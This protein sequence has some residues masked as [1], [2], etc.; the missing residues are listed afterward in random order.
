MTHESYKREIYYINGQMFTLYDFFTPEF[1]TR[2][3]WYRTQY[4]SATKDILGLLPKMMDDWNLRFYT[5]PSALIKNKQGS[6]AGYLLPKVEEKKPT[7]EEYLQM[8]DDFIHDLKYLHQLG[9]C[10]TYEYD[11]RRHKGDKEGLGKSLFYFQKKLSNPWRFA[12][13][14]L[15]YPD[16]RY[17]SI[18]QIVRIISAKVTNEVRHGRKTDKEEKEDTIRKFSRETTVAFMHQ[19]LATAI[20]DL[21][22]GYQELFGRRLPYNF[23]LDIKHYDFWDDLFLSDKPYLPAYFYTPPEKPVNQELIDRINLI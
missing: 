19:S 15:K 11:Y 9:F 1:S 13:V 23:G 12:Y 20:N 7:S 5:R 22:N 10:Y 14:P 8:V 3:T 4:K 17:G 21:Q 16:I 18:H 2:Y 6:V